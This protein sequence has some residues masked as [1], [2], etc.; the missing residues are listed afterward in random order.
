MLKPHKK[1]ETLE[2][3]FNKRLD[4]LQ[5]SVS[6]LTSQQQKQEKG[7]FPSQKQQNPSGLH[8]ESSSSDPNSKLN[9]VKAI[10]TLRSGKELTK[11]SPKAIDPEQEAVD[12]EPREV[13]IKKTVEKYKLC[14]PF[15]QSL[16]TKN[17]AIN[18]AE[19][20]EVLRQ[21]KVNIPLLDMIKQVPTYAKFI[22][23]LCTV[24]K[25]LNIDKKAFLTEKVSS[26]IQC[27]TL[28]KY[29]DPGCPTISVN[30]GGICVAKALLDLGASVNLLPYSMYRQL[31]LGE[32]KPTS[33]TLSL[34]DK[35]IKILKGI[36]EDVLIQVDKFYYS[37][38]FVV[39]DIEPVAARANY[40]PIILGRP[41]LAT[42]N[43][44][45]NCRNGVM[46]LT[47]GNMTLELNIFHLSKKH[48]QP[49][50]DVPEEACI[51]DTIL[52]EQA[53]QQ[54]MLDILDEELT[55]CA[56]E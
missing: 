33:I 6:R 4:D 35:S 36:V 45:I 24:K 44:I 48:M 11:P 16:K 34:A 13:V 38:D 52:E 32:L 18:Q 23:D 12:T 53:H 28:V 54:G 40:V 43:A 47:F 2:G 51:I 56:E 3:T 29:K 46:Q 17:K 8:E 7:K 31:G 49:E 39:L 14:P 37:V 22:K 55:E 41:F 26:I 27:K 50:E 19:I 21:V 15:P 30:I 42:S 25:R 1:I 10:I 20:L 5:C 9:E